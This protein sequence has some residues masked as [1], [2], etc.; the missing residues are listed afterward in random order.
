MKILVLNSIIVCL[1][2]STAFGQTQSDVEFLRARA[3]AH[4]R[5]IS[6]LE[7][8]L[9]RLKALLAEKPATAMAAKPKQT[10]KAL[11]V[12]ATEP[13]ANSYVVKHGDVLSRIATSHQTSV[14]AILKENDL[15]NDRII[16]GQKL[17][18]AGIVASATSSTQVGAPTAKNLAKHQVKS[19]ETF[20]SIAR[21]HNVSMKSLQAANPEVVPT[22][23]YVGQ[24]LRIDGSATASVSNVAKNNQKPQKAA[25]STAPKRTELASREKAPAKESAPSASRAGV[26]PTMRTI[27][28]NQ[29]ITYGQFA[30]RHGASTTQLNEL[31][32][33][34][35][36]KNTTLAK[37]SELYVPKF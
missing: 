28:V 8:D 24:T 1:S 10:P 26:E 34:S 6:Q 35:L 2:V 29:Q 20:Y 18:I 11:A 33:L 22:K 21:I 25:A 17:R 14:A 4:E 13:V 36:S 7:Q 27:T 9:S 31:N 19:G 3:D 23:M 30:S 37:G 16:V 32:G 15:P 12:A 5:K